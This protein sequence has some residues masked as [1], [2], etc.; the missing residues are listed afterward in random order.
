MLKFFCP[1]AEVI[2]RHFTVYRGSV[3]VPALVM[4]LSWESESG[5]DEPDQ[6]V[7]YGAVYQSSSGLSYVSDQ[8]L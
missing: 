6:A 5:F 8:C 1:F 4:L 2:H 3:S 7:S